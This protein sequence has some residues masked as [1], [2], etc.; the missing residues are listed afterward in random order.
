MMKSIVDILYKMDIGVLLFINKTLSNTFFDFLM[1]LFDDVKYWIPIILILWLFLAYI[2]KKNRYKIC[3][4]QI[5][6]NHNRIPLMEIIR[7]TLGV[8]WDQKRV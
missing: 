7:T 5:F 6:K 2:D 1:P 3:C 8:I 4:N